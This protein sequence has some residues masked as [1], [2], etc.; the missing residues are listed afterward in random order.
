[1]WP[2]YLHLYMVQ[3]IR[4]KQKTRESAVHP[5]CFTFISTIHIDMKI[6]A[7]V[8]LS[9]IPL[10][11]VNTL[12]LNYDFL[13][14]FKTHFLKSATNSSDRENE[15]APHSVPHQVAL[16]VTQYHSER[17]FCEGKHAEI[18]LYLRYMVVTF[19]FKF[20]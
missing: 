16:Y 19:F 7:V 20:N 4:G 6:V 14:Y 17:H 8:L 1:M 18:D 3:T 2:L 13:N 11:Q 9:I 15:V 12:L 5:R 10:I